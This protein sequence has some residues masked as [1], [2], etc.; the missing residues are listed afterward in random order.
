MI[1]NTDWECNNFHNI[2]LITPKD[3]PT[4][5]PYAVPY[6]FDFGRFGKCTYASP[7]PLAGTTQVTERWYMGVCKNTRRVANNDNNI[8]RSET[9]ILDLVNNYDLLTKLNKKDMI[10]YL[11]DFST[12]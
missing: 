4:Q 1:G 7:N 10:S 8:Y 11:N 2:K 5:K 12:A 6:D 3:E 9:K